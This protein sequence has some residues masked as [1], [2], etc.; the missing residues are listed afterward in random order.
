MY[1]VDN[2]I[3]KPHNCYVLAEKRCNSCTVKNTRQPQ[4]FDCTAFVKTVHGNVR[5][6]FL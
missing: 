6:Y 4:P 5:I 1:Y 2:L 3:A